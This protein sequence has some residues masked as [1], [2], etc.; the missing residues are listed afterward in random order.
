MTIGA[1]L[2]TF[3][4]IPL[5][6]LDFSLLSSNWNLEKMDE[7]EGANHSFF[8]FWFSNLAPSIVIVS[9]AMGNP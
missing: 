8:F 3:L 4:N 2:F 6:P 9:F 1:F 5:E 7:D